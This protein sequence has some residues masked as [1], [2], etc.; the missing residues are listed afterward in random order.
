[1][2]LRKWSTQFSVAGL[3]ILVR[4]DGNVPIVKGKTQDGPH[5]RIARSAV[6]IHW[7]AQ[8]GAKVIVLSHLGSPEGKRISAYSL[9]PIAKRLGGLL[10]LRV[11]LTRSVV[12][13]DVF[14]AVEKM[15]NG[16]VVL[17]E[18]VRFDVRE[19]SDDHTFAQA[20]ASLGDV[21]VNNAFSVSHRSHTSVH[22]LA[23]LLPSYAGPLLSHEV[24]VLD[25]VAKKGKQPFVL[26]MGGLKMSTK[27]PVIDYLG[28]HVKSLL[29]GGALANAFFV[30][31][32]RAIGKSKVD[33]ESVEIARTLLKEHKHRLL[34]PIDV[35]V[36]TS[37]RKDSKRRVTDVGDVK[38]HEWIVDIGPQTIKLF[39]SV[40]VKAKTIVWNGPLGVCEIEPFCEGTRA[41]AQ[42]IAGCTGKAQTV[43]GGGDT[44]P[45]IEL[46]GLADKFSLLSTGG[47]AMLHFLAG[48]PLP[49]VQVLLGKGK[50]W[51]TSVLTSSF[52]S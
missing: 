16:E 31:Q 40:F 39:S 10:G 9:K 23:E 38:Q 44:L 8:R 33:A 30:A 19:D 47:G 26:L 42:A 22:A 20:L 18:N 48:Q 29:I 11:K 13:K 5:G 32:G 24:E 51:P 35:V 6:H 27:M 7:L 36:A 52:I 17:L 25:H 34:L 37:L 43:V 3:R 28:P 49:G 14:K 12:G 15:Q 4:I 45:I 46:L 2:T 41:V 1:M 21:Y 50:K